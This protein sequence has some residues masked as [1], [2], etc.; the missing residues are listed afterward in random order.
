MFFLTPKKREL[1]TKELMVNTPNS[2]LRN[3]GTKPKENAIKG[4]SEKGEDADNGG[5]TSYIYG[6]LI[7]REEVETMYTGLETK[8]QNFA[9]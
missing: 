7:W 6:S 1:I 8:Y 4:K 9:P 5:S 3:N 2:A